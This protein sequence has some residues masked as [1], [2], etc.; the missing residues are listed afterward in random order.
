MATLPLQI[1]F[2]QLGFFQQV[3]DME[4]GAFDESLHLAQ[5]LFEFVGEFVV[6]L[7]A[8]GLGEPPHSLRKCR[9][10]ITQLF[11]GVKELRIAA[12]APDRRLLAPSLKSLLG[13]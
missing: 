13:V 12:G 8:P 5:L 10:R 11:N 3:R 4:L 9:C 2:D 6:F 7:V 1:L